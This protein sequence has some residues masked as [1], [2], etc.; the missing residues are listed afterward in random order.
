MYRK[1]E[2]RKYGVNPWKMKKNIHK[3]DLPEKKKY[4]FK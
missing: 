2:F 3:Q 4:N 1:K